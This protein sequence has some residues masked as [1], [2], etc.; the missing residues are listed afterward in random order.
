MAAV[1]WRYIWSCNR[2]CDQFV[3]LTELRRVIP[4]V[5]KSLG[6][7]IPRWTLEAGGYV[8]ELFAAVITGT[9]S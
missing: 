9:G 7:C 2:K 3:C 1:K 5:A 8:L 4:D 6:R